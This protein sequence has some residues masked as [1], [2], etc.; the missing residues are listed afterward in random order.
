MTDQA[1]PTT[2]ETI[3]PAAAAGEDR[4]LPGAI[5]VLYI[6]GLFC[7]G[8]TTLL[9]LIL[10]YLV[11]DTAGPKNQTHY[12]FLIRT[13]WMSLGWFLIGGLLCIFG[14]VLSLIL[15]GI[16]ALMLGIFIVCTV[17]VWFAVRCVMG[18]VYLARDE[19]HPRPMT[20]LV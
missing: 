18:L 20:W 11:K 16:P 19:A 8:L 2:A 13:V 10:A 9:G 5:Y 14:G 7:G 15:V 6:V 17:G 3:P 12:D 4:V 1:A